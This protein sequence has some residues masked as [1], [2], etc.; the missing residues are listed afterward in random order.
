[1]QNTLDT[2]YRWS[3]GEKQQNTWAIIGNDTYRPSPWSLAKNFVSSILSRKRSGAITSTSRPSMEAPNPFSASSATMKFV[4][5]CSLWYTSSAMSSNTGKTI[6]NQ[7]RYPVTL[8]FVQFGFIAMYCLLC[9]SPVV[10]LSKL[11][12]PTKAIIRSTAPMAVFQVGGHIFSSVAIARIPVSTV[13]TIKVC[14]HY[15]SRRES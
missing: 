2:G 8:T 13:H 11:R 3:L 15:G 12:P 14:F 1:M 4:F 6:L 10:Q 9:M 5:L 7:F